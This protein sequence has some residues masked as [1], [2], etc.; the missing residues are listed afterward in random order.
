[1]ARAKAEI[2]RELAARAREEDPRLAHASVE[3]AARM[4][5]E[6]LAALDAAC[7]ALDLARPKNP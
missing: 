6:S 7:A 1:M 5:A 3:A 2:E 4:L